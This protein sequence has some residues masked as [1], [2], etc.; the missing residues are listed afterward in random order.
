MGNLQYYKVVLSK[1]FMPKKFSPN[2]LLDIPFVQRGIKKVF[3]EGDDMLVLPRNEVIHVDESIDTPIEE[4]L[5]TKVIEH[6]IK[7]ACY[8]CMI[9]TCLCRDALQCKDYPIENG[10]LYIGEAAKG[11]HPKLGRQV[12]VD[13][14]LEHVRRSQ[15]LGLVSMLGRSKLDCIT[16]SIG[17]GNKLMAV[18]N[19]CPCCCVSRAMAIAPP[20]LGETFN[21]IPGMRISV[22]DKCQG[23]GTC[24]EGCMY[25]A[26]SLINS[27]ATIDYSRCMGCSRCVSNCPNGAVEV[28]IEDDNY[29]QNTIDRL[30]KAVDV[31]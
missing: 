6:F 1:R 19:C 24:A 20:A 9:N 14:A 31:T 28:L 18:C 13:E 16:H 26:M 8:I 4:V 23:C 25:H 21:I 29:I 2:K 12:S 17:P 30:S 5:P 7:K 10:C 27:R 15:E 3:L 22:T 11:V